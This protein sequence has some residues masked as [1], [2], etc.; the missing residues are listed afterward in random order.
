MWC[1]LLLLSLAPQSQEEA[2]LLTAADADGGDQYGHAIASSGNRLLIGAP[3]DEAAA[4]FAG[5]AYLLRREQGLWV[6]E[7]KLL[8]SDAALSDRFGW[9]LALEG[10]VAVVSALF[11]DGAQ[12]VSGAAYSFLRNGSSWQEMQKIMPA[13]GHSSDWFGRSLAI[14][15]NTCVIGAPQVDDPV[16]GIDC[17]AAYVYTLVGAQWVLQE[18]VFA[19]DAAAGDNF[20]Q[21]V[22]ISG[23]SILVG[24]PFDDDLGSRSGSAYVYTR[25]ASSW[26]FEAKLHAPSGASQDFF[27]YAVAL[28]QEVAVV[29]AY[30][31][32][33][34]GSQQHSGVGYAYD[35]SGVQWSGGQ[36]LVPAAAQS[37]DDFGWSVAVGQDLIL[38]GGR[39]HLG[40]GAAVRFHRGAAT[41]FED[42]TLVPVAAAG[43]ESWGHAVVIDGDRQLVSSSLATTAGVANGA[44][45]VMRAFQLDLHPRQ[46]L[47]GQP[48]TLKLQGAQVGMP[49]WLARSVL[50]NGSFAVP[51]LGL[52]LDLQAPQ[53]L[54]NQRVANAIG[55]ST[56]TL[57]VPA[58]AA[59]L[60]VWIQGLQAGQTSN[61]RAVTLL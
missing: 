2:F 3:L 15:G 40:S 14:A 20:G 48:L 47:A 30:Q 53:P 51:S 24:A 57:S 61:L 7:A 8:A 9:A 37:G 26:P 5:S 38:L 45:A 31:G 10:D 33:A 35:R 46:P 60:S 6:E 43:L 50:G 1:A 21:S 18:K 29:G 39:D 44:V 28:H 23:D 16:F 56:W 22:A 12:P 41:W 52:I 11:G 17:G 4:L 19:P 58:G 27:G 55:V 25:L 54:G 32:A 49:T 42:T 59:G 34:P 36:P 13:D